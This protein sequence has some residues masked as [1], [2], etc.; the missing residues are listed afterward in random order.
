MIY[1]KAQQSPNRHVLLL[2][3]QSVYFE[4]LAKMR[5]KSDLAA[6][7]RKIHLSLLDLAMKQAV[8]NDE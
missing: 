8:V 4:Q 1:R 7:H 5:G 3:G 2:L 6:K